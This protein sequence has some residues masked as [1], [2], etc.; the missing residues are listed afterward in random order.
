MIKIFFKNLTTLKSFI[1]LI[2]LSIILTSILTSVIGCR[3]TTT[4]LR[5]PDDSYTKSDKRRDRRS[6][7]R[8]YDCDRYDKYDHPRRCEDY[9]YDDDD[10]DDDDNYDDRY[11][12]DDKI[13]STFIIERN[14]FEVLF[15]SGCDS[16]YQDTIKPKIK[17]FSELIV[18]LYSAK[19]ALI[20]CEAR[21]WVTRERD[22][23][24]AEN[25][26]ITLNRFSSSNIL[27]TILDV[28]DEDDGSLNDFFSE[29]TTKFFIITV[30]DKDPRSFHKFKRY[31]DDEHDDQ[32][33]N[34]YGL[35]HTGL[36]YL[37]S[38]QAIDDDYYQLIIRDYDGEFFSLNDSSSSW[39]PLLLS[40]IVK[41]SIKKTYTVRKKIKRI[42]EVYIGGKSKTLS[43]VSF[44]GKQITI[45]NEYLKVGSSVKITYEPED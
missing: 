45:K 16:E 40:H 43:S 2:S 42:T 26:N 6:D 19:F 27:S 13:T 36:R 38:R 12:D 29:D 9:D 7:R 34:F 3:T 20:T 25:Q 11:N 23:I 37:S 10:R 14:D 33:V 24:Y 5:K 41:H 30:D 18:D 4:D 21:N 15:V 8:H 31:L 32:L 39:S 35:Y 17:D 44:S 1:C 22:K 28:T